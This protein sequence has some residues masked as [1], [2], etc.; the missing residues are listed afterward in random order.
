M[1]QIKTQQEVAVMAEGGKILREIL[2]NLAQAVR[3]GL[4]TEE[5]DKL[6]RELVLSWAKKL[7]KAKIGSSFCGYRGFPGFVCVSVNDEV[8]HGIPSVKKIMTEGDIVGL[9][10]GIIYQGF[11][12]DSAVTVPVGKVSKEVEKLLR[13]TQESLELGIQEAIVGQTVGDI[14]YAVQKHAE[15]NGFGVV[16]ELVG[17]GVG[18]K[19]HEEP[20][21]PNYGRKGEGEILKE[22]MV[23]AIEPMITAGRP[24]VEIAPD[25]WTYKTKDHS[26]AAHFE[27]TVAITKEG[28]K[29]LT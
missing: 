28:P 25:G 24:A 3:P 10:F 26:L 20:Y 16:K 17:H 9:D 14:G 29:I 1:I 7:P 15:K 8:V 4:T 13:V 27:H 22:G 19:L 5:I 18:R 11:H 2:Q 6:A 23:I 21:I 12:T